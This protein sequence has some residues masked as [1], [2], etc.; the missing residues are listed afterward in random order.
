MT[1]NPRA[2]DVAR[3]VLE[4]MTRELRRNIAERGREFVDKLVAVQN[5]LGSAITQVQ[6]TG[7][8]FS[9]ELDAARYRGYGADSIEEYM[10]IHGINVIHGGENSLRFT[11]HFA[12]T[13]EEVD[14]IVAATRRALEKGPLKA[15][16][17]QSVAA[18]NAEDAAAA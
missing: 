11:P 13:S 10:R 1:S 6:G 8:L 12:I 17:E 14:L 3:A 5:D 2:M 15:G 4:A 18:A 16:A 7:L 9:I